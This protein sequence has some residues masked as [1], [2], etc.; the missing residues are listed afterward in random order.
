MFLVLCYN[1]DA[2]QGFLIVVSCV[3]S[4]YYGDQVQRCG[5]LLPGPLNMIMLF[6]K[7]NT[8]FD[9]QATTISDPTELFDK[10]RRS[11]LEPT[12]RSGRDLMYEAWENEAISSTHQEFTPYE[13]DESTKKQP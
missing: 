2:M 10:I 8:T 3:V 7:G 11:H 5:S 4:L 12:Y 9:L 6:D 13:L 1:Q